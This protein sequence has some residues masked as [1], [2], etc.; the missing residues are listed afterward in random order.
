MVRDTSTLDASSELRRPSRRGRDGS[1]K[2]GERQSARE[3]PQARDASSR[4]N[5]PQSGEA[6]VVTV[7]EGL[8]RWDAAGRRMRRDRVAGGLV[9]E[10][11][12]RARPIE[13]GASAS[14]AVTGGTSP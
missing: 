3:S 1:G 4:L 6:T 5:R 10:L 11:K 12:A 13:R 7:A 9:A 2:P 8:V 14:V